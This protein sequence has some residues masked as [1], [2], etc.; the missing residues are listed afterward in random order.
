MLSLSDVVVVVYIFRHFN[1]YIFTELNEN[2]NE[3]DRSSGSTGTGVSHG[4]I[5]IFCKKMRF[6]ALFD[7]VNVVSVDDNMHF[8]IPLHFLH[9]KVL[10]RKLYQ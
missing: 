4:R 2:N 10:R 9:K 6:K 7:T 5:S 1:Q 3:E 8:Q